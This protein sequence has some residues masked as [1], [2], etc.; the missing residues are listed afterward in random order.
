MFTMTSQRNFGKH[1]LSLVGVVTTVLACWFVVHEIISTSSLDNPHWRLS[2]VWALLFLMAL[3][4]A[5]LGALL[6]RAWLT[7]LNICSPQRFTWGEGMGIYAKTQILKYLPLNIFHLV[8]RYA[9]LWYRSLPHSVI[10]SATLGELISITVTATLF[11]LIFIFPLLST[12][13]VNYLTFSAF[14]LW[15]TLVCLSSL[16]IGGVIVWQYYNPWELLLVKKLIRA[17]SLTLPLHAVFF[18]ATAFIAMV[19][20]QVG[21]DSQT[22]FPFVRLLGIMTFAS[23]IGFIVP[24]SPGGIGVRELLIIYGLEGAVDITAATFLALSYRIVTVSGDIFFA[25][26]GIIFTLKSTK[27]DKAV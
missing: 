23:L 3:V 5:I 1:F 18:C 11:S 4:Y 20:L 7:I 9:L 14:F 16:A 12:F 25:L 26:W 21:L 22:T 19:L 15:M 24:G 10:M 2:K 6:A 17:L 13:I 8:G 27:Y